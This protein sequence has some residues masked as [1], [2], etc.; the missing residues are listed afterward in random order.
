MRRLTF[1]LRGRNRDG[2]WPARRSIDRQRLAGQVPC[3]WRSCSSEGLGLSLEAGAWGDRLGCCYWLL[4]L[5]D[6][7]DPSHSLGGTDAASLF[8]AFEFGVV[9]GI[10]LGPR[11]AVV[12]HSPRGPSAIPALIAQLKR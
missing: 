10:S 9:T 12:H 6:L 11:G 1:E 2:A 3:R 4:T 5:D 8:V 7:F